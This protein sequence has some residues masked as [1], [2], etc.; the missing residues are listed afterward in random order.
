MPEKEKRRE[1]QKNNEFKK[2]FGKRVPGKYL[3]KTTRHWTLENYE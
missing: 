3:T 2:N 1:N